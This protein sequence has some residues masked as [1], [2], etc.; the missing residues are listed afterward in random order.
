MSFLLYAG[1]KME[2]NNGLTQDD[3]TSSLEALDGFNV[4]ESDD[5]QNKNWKKS[6]WR[7]GGRL[8][9]TRDK[10]DALHG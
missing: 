1:D 2:D 7:A 9:S 10:L 3:F 6:Y 8:L 4:T 5:E